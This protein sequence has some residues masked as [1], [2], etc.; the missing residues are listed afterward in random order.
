MDNPGAA[1]NILVAVSASSDP[2]AGWTGFAIDSDT[3]NQQWADFPMF[4]LDADAVYV[5]ANMFPVQQGGNFEINVLTIPKA[6]L[7]AATPTVANATLIEN[8][9]AIGFSP[10]PAVDFGP[11]DGRAPLL[12]A[13]P[14][15]GNTLTRTDVLGAG[16]ANATLSASTT[17]NV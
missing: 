16:A 10:H 12:S 6:D 9:V 2:T 1:N 17:I 14:N 4:G 7:L 13:D 11:S 15:G 3:D 5:T 8:Q